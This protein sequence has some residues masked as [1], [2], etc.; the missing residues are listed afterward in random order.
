[1]F[2]DFPPNRP[3]ATE[4]AVTTLVRRRLVQ[5]DV[6]NHGGDVFSD[7]TNKGGPSY[8]LRNFSIN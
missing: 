6:K 1:M 3:S 5:F 2:T 7:M 4:Y 8:Y